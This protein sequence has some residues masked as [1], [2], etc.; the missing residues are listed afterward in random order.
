MT[1]G[2]MIAREKYSNAA[3]AHKL[4]HV[5]LIGWIPTLTPLEANCEL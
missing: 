1:L 2:R 4:Q 3:V 5:L